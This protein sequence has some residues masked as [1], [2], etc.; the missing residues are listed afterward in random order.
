[1]PRSVARALRL[2]A[3]HPSVRGIESHFDAATGV[4]DAVV[5]I[6]AH[7]PSRWR[8]R[9]H[10]DNGVLAIEPVSIRFTPD[11]PLREPYIV[12]RA[13]FDRSH[14]HLQ[15]RGPNFPPEPCLL[16]GSVRELLQSRDIIG[17]I[18]QLVEWI[19]RAALVRLNDPVGGWEITRRDGI[20][21]LVILNSGWVRS[22]AGRDGGCDGFGAGYAATRENG[23]PETYRVLL[24]DIRHGLSENDCRWSGQVV[25]DSERYGFALA[26]VAWSGRTPSGQPFIAA[27]YLPETVVDVASLHARAHALGCGDQ[28]RAKLDLLQRRMRGKTSRAAQPC[29]IILLARRPFNLTGG[30]SPIEIC[31]YLIELFGND[32]LG[33][34]SHKPVRLVAPHDQ[35]S[36]NLLREASGEDGAGSMRWTLLGCGSVGSKIATH[37]MRCGRG[38]SRLVDTAPM[39]PHNYARHALFPMN[40]SEQH[41]GVNKASLL[42]SSLV[43]FTDGKM[44][45][46]A[47]A[48]DI[49]M[50][51][52]D[53]AK[54]GAVFGTEADFVVN[55]TGSLVVREALSLPQVTVI[56]PRCVETCLLGAGRLAYMAVEGPAA[57]PSVADLAAEAYR[58]LAAD[59]VTAAAVFGPEAEAT[60][61]SIGQGCSSLTFPMTDAHLSAMTAPIAVALGKLHATGLPMA[62]GEIL[63]GLGADDGLGQSWIRQP[64]PPWTVVETASERGPGVRVS[65]RVD[66]SIAREVAA[67]PGSET[68]G[69]IVGRY[70]DVT[71]TFH[72]V[73]VLSAPPDSRFSAD[74]FV[75]GIDGLSE[76]IDGLV[77]RNG[78]ALYPLGTWH[79]H[80]VTSGHSAKDLATAL[81]LAAVQIFPLLMLI[82]TPGGYRTLVTEFIEHRPAG[83]PLGEAA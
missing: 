68:G 66:A 26:L 10:S 31:P 56:R 5:R 14:P 4:T 75:L 44:A 59:N 80:L 82:H 28:L 23:A 64:V 42:A 79:N 1:M 34:T 69:I 43:G 48:A 38:P 22:L 33:P 58:I 36:P 77:E 13:D 54:A 46:A 24:S 55:A 17:V 60:R 63:I 72:V 25:S 65:A 30:H 3:L 78:G 39:R 9:G 29:I 51:M 57:N 70:S 62:G 74:E 76:R 71:D 67:R 6:D 11:Y 81:K 53:P 37:M 40:V 15:P 19:G 16:F 45:L 8:V 18:D 20:H 2:I 27:S 47:I 83:G 52:G 41:Q 12:L 73:D 49:P 32:E 21:D 61:I 7:L 50:A 35:V